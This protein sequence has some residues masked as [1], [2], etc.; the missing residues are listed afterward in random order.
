M[1]LDVCRPLNSTSNSTVQKSQTSDKK[2]HIKFSFGGQKRSPGFHAL[3]FGRFFANT[4]VFV[5]SDTY[6]WGV[7]TDVC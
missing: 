5:L 4:L 7:F 1:T 3:T 2:S 6:L